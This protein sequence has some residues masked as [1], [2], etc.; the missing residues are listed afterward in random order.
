MLFTEP[1]FIFLF[2]PIVILGFHFFNFFSSNFALLFLSVSSLIFYSWDQPQYVF[3]LIYVVLISWIMGNLIRIS[4]TN[5]KSLLVC[6]II[7][8]LLP[9][10][11]Y[12]YLYFIIS[13]INLLFF[14][15]SLDVVPE[16]I[17]VKAK[18]IILPIGISFYTFQSIS[19]LVDIYTGQIKDRNNFI[20]YSAYVTMFPQLVAG[21]I[22]RFKE[23]SNQL[24]NPHI[25][26]DNIRI[27]TYFFIIGL[28]K[29]VLIADTLAPFVDL[30]FDGENNNIYNSC[31]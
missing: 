20:K 17:I 7:L 22:V 2:F 9:L 27:G 21:P 8:I 6:S 10:I 16:N 11:F 1:V 3:I 24:I 14:S 28:A 13:N 31:N 29:K 25:T 19:Y 5:K 4:E 26:S 18:S 23:I 30:I 15:V 12:K